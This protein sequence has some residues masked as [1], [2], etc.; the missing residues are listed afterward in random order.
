M[1]R[2]LLTLNVALLATLQT[3]VVRLQIRGHDVN[4]AVLTSIIMI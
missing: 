4:D 3:D 1:N 2:T